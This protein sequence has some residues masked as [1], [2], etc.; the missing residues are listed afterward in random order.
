MKRRDGVGERLYACSEIKLT[1]LP[2]TSV[3]SVFHLHLLYL[4]TPHVSNILKSHWQTNP[5]RSKPNRLFSFV[6]CNE[7]R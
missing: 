6:V 4:Y 5:N 7:A 3:N 1:V 2:L